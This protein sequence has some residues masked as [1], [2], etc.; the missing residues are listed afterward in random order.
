MNPCPCGYLGD[1]SGL[2]HCSTDQVARYRSRISGLLLDRI[3][4]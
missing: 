2:C 3:D 1:Q 4:L